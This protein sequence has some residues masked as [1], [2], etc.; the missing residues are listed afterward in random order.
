MRV[1]L[2]R[3]AAFVGAILFWVL[4]LVKLVTDWIGRTTVLD[5]ANQLAERMPVIVGW[6]LATPWWVPGG[7][8]TALTVFLLWAGWPTDR[9]RRV[10][11][12]D[13]YRDLGTS[14]LGVAQQIEYFQWVGKY[15]GSNA[16]LG[17]EIYAIMVRF[18]D[19]GFPVPNISPSANQDERLSKALE[20]L[21]V[22]GALLRDGSITE[23]T[24]FAIMRS[25][26]PNISGTMASRH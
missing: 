14:A 10:A 12:K 4:F 13:R 19:M 5:D 3:T 7:L 6:L 15:A 24:E 8:A 16:T 17:S 9:P 26:K 18:H 22:M 1:F 25:T 20:Y 21:S 11:R 2:A 23:A